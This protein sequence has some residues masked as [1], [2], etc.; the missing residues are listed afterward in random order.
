M[1]SSDTHHTDSRT[2]ATVAFKANEELSE[3]K[4]ENVHSLFIFARQAFQSS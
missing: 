2:V 3:Q 4:S 1:V